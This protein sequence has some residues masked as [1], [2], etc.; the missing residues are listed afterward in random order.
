MPAGLI[1]V[2][3]EDS[4]LAEAI[5]ADR[6]E[7]AIDDC[8]ARELMLQPGSWS[9]GET[10]ELQDGVGLL[11]LNGLMIRH[12][13]LDGRYGAE[14]LGEGDILRP[15]QEER[16]TSLLPLTSGWTVVGPTRAAVLDERFAQH[17][18]RYPGLAS[19][20][21]ARGI[22]RSRHLAVQLAIVN[23]SRID[24]RLHM[25]FWQLASRWGRVRSDGTTVPLRLTHSV[26]AELVA[27]RRPTV[28]T[29]L[30]D[31]S[32]RR[33]VRFVDDVW[34]LTG[35]PPGELADAASG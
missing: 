25:L 17:F 26:L 4:E 16:T 18:G 23:Q 3:R 19:R 32:R 8:T 21:L 1:N 10:T 11:V 7:Q 15:W 33:L 12:V 28:T 22:D 9:P 35:Q 30:S 5:P 27:A 2:L 34:L 31:L 29:A 13:G 20:L 24:I 6:R 14:L